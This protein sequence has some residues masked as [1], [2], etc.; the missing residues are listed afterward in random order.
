[1]KISDAPIIE[2]VVKAADFVREAMYAV[3]AS[4]D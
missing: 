1:M 2:K 4:A 3:N